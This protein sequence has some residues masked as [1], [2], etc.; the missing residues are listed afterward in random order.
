MNRKT[1]GAYLEICIV[2]WCASALHA[3]E[4]KVAPTWLYRNTATAPEKPSDI[5]TAT[6]HYKPI[7]GAGD[8]DASALKSVARYGEAVID[9][10]GVCATVQYAQEDQILVVLE[11]SGQAQ[12]GSEQVRLKKEDYLYFPATVSHALKNTSTSPMTVVIMGFRAK[13]YDASTLPTHPL[14][15]NIEDIATEFVSGHPE[16]THYRLLLGDDDGENDHFDVRRE[17]TSFFLMQI[18]PAG[19]NFPHHHETAEE[20][21]LILSGH[22]TIIAG[23]G[24]DGVEGRHSAKAGD[25][26]FYRQNATV[27]YY[28]AAG[29]ESRL[30]CVRSYVPGFA[31]ID[32]APKSQA[33]A[34]QN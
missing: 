19:T 8:A 21:Y 23:G 1:I 20:I 22:G 29:V 7:F 26:Y 28:S 27:G 2:L 12:Y 32:R 13:G 17:V 31:P 15:A 24:M 16:S 3:Q 11:G 9:A 6:C 25:A 14:K 4:R 33:H 10:N 30:L 34:S 18:D 5:T